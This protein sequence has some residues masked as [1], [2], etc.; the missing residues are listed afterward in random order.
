MCCGV[1]S[2]EKDVHLYVGLTAWLV[3]AVSVAVLQL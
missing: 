1:V 2:V 3:I